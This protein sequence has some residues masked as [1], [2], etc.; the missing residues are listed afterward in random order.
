M[1]G[2]SFAED[3]ATPSDFDW[4]LS[5]GLGLT[6]ITPWLPLPEDITPGIY[7]STKLTLIDYKQGL[8]TGGFQAV[9]TKALKDGR[10]LPDVW[11][12]GI[13]VNLNKVISQIPNASW[14]GDIAVTIGC[15]LLFKEDE[16][17]KPMANL[18]LSIVRM[19]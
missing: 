8:I 7:P 15:G 1:C 3:V 17:D 19:F 9:W 11:G 6:Y 14:V 4:G 18:S 13:N 5:G 10:V 2:V 16:L 12:A